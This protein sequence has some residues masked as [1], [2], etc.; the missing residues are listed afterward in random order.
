MPFHLFLLHFVLATQQQ[1]Q[2]PVN[3][4]DIEKVHSRFAFAPYCKSIIQFNSWNCQNVC[5]GESNGTIID[6]VRYDQVGQLVAH[7]THND[8]LK[9]I[10]VAFRGAQTKKAKLA[11][12][13]L[14]LTRYEGANQNLEGTKVHV[15]F[16]SV[17]DSSKTE[18]MDAVYAIATQ[19]PTYQIVFTGHSMGGALALL[20]AVNYYQL[21]GDDEMSSRMNLVTYGQPRVGNTAFASY[22]DSLPFSLR[23]LRV[24]KDGDPI[25]DVPSKMFGYQHCGNVVDYEQATKVKF[26]GQMNATMCET[27]L[28]GSDMNEHDFYWN[29]IG[30]C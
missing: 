8:Q 25:V 19:Y 5:K 13:R 2:Q 24:I 4:H 10:N 28:R 16:K 17:Y 23:Y 12:A 9:S 1:Q 18:I 22:V 29:W 15:G 27:R 7:V 30:K 21:H 26:C 11:A 3:Y 14:R 20:A 6:L